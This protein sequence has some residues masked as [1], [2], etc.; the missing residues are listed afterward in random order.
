M[1]L[2]ISICNT[3]VPQINSQTLIKFSKLWGGPLFEGWVGPYL[4]VGQALIREEHFAIDFTSTVESL[5]TDTPR[6]IPK[7]PSQR[8]VCLID[9]LKR[10]DIRQKELKVQLTVIG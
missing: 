9:V 7:C 1:I 3:V 2:Y 10:I 5:K 6:D 8:G 4:R